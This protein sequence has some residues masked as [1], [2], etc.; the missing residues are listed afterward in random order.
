[1]LRI[2]TYF[3][4]LID[5]L[6]QN[7]SSRLLY[8]GLQGSYFRGEADEIS[9]I[10]VMVILDRL[11]VNDMETYREIIAECGNSDKSCGFICGESDI[12]N[13]NPCEI[14]QLV[15]TTKDYYGRLSEFVPTYTVE[16]E[17]TYIKMSLNNLY[18]ELC[19]RYIHDSRAK[20][21]MK[22]P[23][24]YKSVF[25]ILQNIHFQNTGNFI[26]TKRELLSQLPDEDKKVLLK[27]M[28]LKNQKEYHFDE[29]FSALFEWCQNSIFKS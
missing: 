12:K 20:N 7:Y 26:L 9:D 22:L 25:F 11:S 8:V 2:D 15:H 24:T 29:Y 3:K 6:K 10:D 19:H 1:M 28:E 21:I 16:D 13:W 4:E 14:C 17:R 5:L 27:A 23:G 18:H